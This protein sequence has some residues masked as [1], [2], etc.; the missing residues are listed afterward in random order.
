MLSLHVVVK[1]KC[2]DLR[3]LLSLAICVCKCTEVQKKGDN[4]LLLSCE[5]FVTQI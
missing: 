4:L 3:F 2:C 1:G 5:S